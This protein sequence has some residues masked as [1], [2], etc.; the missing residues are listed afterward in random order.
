MARVVTELDGHLATPQALT[1]RQ[2]LRLAAA[3]RGGFADLMRAALAESHTRALPA[4]W[5]VIDAIL[6]ESEAEARDTTPPDPRPG[7][8]RRLLTPRPGL[9]IRRELAPEGWLLRFTGPEATGALIED[10]LDEV[11]RIFGG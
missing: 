1:Q 11:E 7:R 3:C 10:V 9:K 2:M 6:T 5:R 4:Q 8:P